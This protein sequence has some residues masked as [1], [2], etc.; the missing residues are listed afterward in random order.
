MLHNTPPEDVVDL[1]LLRSESLTQQTL[2]IEQVK[3]KVI[4]SLSLSAE[5]ILCCVEALPLDKLID[6]SAQITAACASRHFHTC[7]IINVKSGRCSEDCKWCAQS[8]HYAT[9]ALE[10]DVK[11]PELCC[12]DAHKAQAATVEMFSF[13]SSG[14]RPN[15]ASFTKLLQSIDAVKSSEPI[16][17][18]ASLGLA[19]PEMLQALKEHGITR[20]HCNLES[21]PNFFPKLCTTHTFEQKIQTLKAARQA[22][23]ELCSGGI[24]GMGEDMHDRL[25]LALALR[26][27]EITS[28]PINVLHPIAGTPLEKQPRLSDEEIIRSVALFRLTLPHAALR[29]A[30]GRDLM[31]KE[32]QKQCIQAGINAAIVGT[33]LTTSNVEAI[34]QDV[35]QLTATKQS[36]LQKYTAAT[37]A[38]PIPQ[39]A[40][41]SQATP[42]THATQIV[43]AAAKDALHVAATHP[44]PKAE[45]LEQPIAF[46]RLP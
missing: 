15:R 19:T 6:L 45:S 36:C 9:N 26:E 35:L 7:A 37:L 28:V 41:T 18:C 2:G 10:Y 20:Y 30:G 11:A 4:S 22:G 16:A 8:Q 12:Q 3:A 38:T 1:A 29:F 32:L 17:L 24:I 23:L 13:V 27:L 46:K 44:T 40:Q 42:V 25:E 39:I 33:L 31:S 5:E 14:R 34:H 21:S 43:Q